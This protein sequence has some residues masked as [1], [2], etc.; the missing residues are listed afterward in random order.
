M[1]ASIKGLPFILIMRNDPGAQLC[2]AGRGDG[3]RK[4]IALMEAV[5]LC[6]GMGTRLRSVVSDRPKPLADVEGRA[7]MEYP[8]AELCSWFREDPVRK[9]V[10]A[11][12]YKGRMV[13]EHFGDGS[14]WGFRAAYA[15][16]DEPLGTAG[17]IR[18]ALSFLTEERAFVLNA[19]TFY[20]IDY[21]AMAAKMDEEGTDMLLV[22]REVPDIS[23]YG[24]VRTGGGLLIGWNEKVRES[25]AG[26]INGGIYLMKRSLIESIPKDR[27]IS[28]ENEMI[29]RWISEGVRIGVL[30]S[31]GYFI[32]IGVP[33]SYRRFK[34]DA[35]EFG[36]GMGFDALQGKARQNPPFGRTN[37]Q[38]PGG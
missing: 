38:S 21:R 10:F 9:I 8:V 27:K 35:K 37:P 16:E 19:D 18:N 20:R 36:K 33:E 4:G 1:T 6:G 2:G 22:T 12:G 29:P 11:A 32:D 24:E 17:A 23:R 3:Y 31:D 28:L 25:R 5:F 14:R 13:E 26:E 15:Y 34:E 7:F 30:H